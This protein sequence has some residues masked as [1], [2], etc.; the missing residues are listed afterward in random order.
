MNDKYNVTFSAFFKMALLVLPGMITFVA[1][2][3][4]S[5]FGRNC[6]ILSLFLMLCMA[7][8]YVIALYIVYMKIDERGNSES[9]KVKNRTIALIYG[10]RTAVRMGL[11]LFVLAECSRQLMLKRYTVIAISIPLLFACLYMGS[12]GTRGMV[13]FAESVF[14]FAVAAGAVVILSS[15]SNLDLSVLKTVTEIGDEGGANLTISRVMAR[16]GLLFLGFS[17]METV[18]LVYIHVIR[19]RR[20][21]L[22]AAVGT[23]TII[24][25]MC[26]II[27]ICTLGTGALMAKEKN[28]LY[29][30]GAMELP[31]GVKLRPLMLV[32]YLVIVF[33]VMALV[34]NVIGGWGA[35]DRLG[36]RHRWLWKTLWAVLAFAVCLWAGMLPGQQDRIKIISGYLI[37][38]DVPL[39]I[40]LPA[41]SLAGKWPVKKSAGLAAVLLTACILSGCE[42]KPV[43]DVVLH[44]QI[45]GG[46][47]LPN[48]KNVVNPS[49]LMESRQVITGLDDDED[50]LTEEGV[51]QVDAGSFADACRSYN[52]SHAKS[53]D[54]SHVEYIVA[55]DTQV[56]NEAAAELEK[57]FATSYVTVVIEQNILEKT[58]D[59][60]T[61]EYLKTHY[62]GQCLAT[63]A[64]DG[65]CE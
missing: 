8:A 38:V 4:P 45:E 10:A 33:G 49:M 16:G 56:M 64:R 61:N 15:V 59:N 12:R 24:G 35:V 19:R 40:I 31:G 21:M 60:N 30:V 48:V 9:G 41:A 52:E 26:S 13:R 32:C 5:Y 34:P 63:Y 53:L 54:T 22:C 11:L 7:F 46:D 23:S 42:Y 18:V 65:I 20:G 37:L 36:V 47:I 51:Y 17:A 57:E 43:E 28:I 2:L 58:G 3:I 44:T 39:S 6:L 29:I 50:S 27:V 55:E 62:E 14:W 25:I 1:T